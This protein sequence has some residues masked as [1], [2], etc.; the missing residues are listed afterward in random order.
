MDR[1]EEQEKAGLGAPEHNYE[2][3]GEVYRV[4][5]N[6]LQDEWVFF[7]IKTNSVLVW[8]PVGEP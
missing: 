5:V 2:F 3:T 4:L 6:T 8:G 7:F 1:Q